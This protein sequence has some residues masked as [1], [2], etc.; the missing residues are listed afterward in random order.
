MD[1]V[2]F[3]P[4]TNDPVTSSVADDAQVPAWQEI[5]PGRFRPRRIRG[6]FLGREL[7]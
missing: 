6:S 4:Q 1:I 3:D 2:S 7:G 5:E